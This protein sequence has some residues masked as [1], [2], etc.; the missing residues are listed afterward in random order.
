MAAFHSPRKVFR[1][2]DLHRQ[3][4]AERDV[5]NQ[6]DSRLRT[7]DPPVER[8]IVKT[9]RITRLEVLRTPIR[10]EIGSLVRGEGNMN[11]I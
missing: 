5:Q 7:V 9:L 4:F 1:P 8:L 6:V 11:P 10:N 2:I 3:S